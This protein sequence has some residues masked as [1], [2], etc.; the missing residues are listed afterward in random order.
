MSWV[1]HW[2]LD[3][4]TKAHSFPSTMVQ[5]VRRKKEFCNCTTRKEQKGLMYITFLDHCKNDR[6]GSSVSVKF[7]KHFLL[8]LFDVC[9]LLVLWLPSISRFSLSSSFQPPPSSSNLLFLFSISLEA[10]KCS[11]TSGYT[12]IAWFLP[13][14]LTHYYFSFS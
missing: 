8:K 14:F 4:V 7:L 5:H 1:C 2:S 6:T 12:I 10:Y 11:F 3:L 13:K 9:F